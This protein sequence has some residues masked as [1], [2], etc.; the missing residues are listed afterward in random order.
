MLRYG[1]RSG[2]QTL[3]SR[4]VQG[5]V[6]LVVGGELATHACVEGTKAIAK[7]NLDWSWGY[8]GKQL[9]TLSD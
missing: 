1:F 7:N 5:A 3:T 9:A 8:K 2:R 4:D 6:R